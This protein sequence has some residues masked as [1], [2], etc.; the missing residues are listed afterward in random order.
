MGLGTAFLL[1]AGM[2]IAVAKGL[3]RDA[4]LVVFAASLGRFAGAWLSNGRNQ[5][6][7]GSSAIIA[8][9]NQIELS[10]R[11][12]ELALD[13]AQK[14]AVTKL[15]REESGLDFLGAIH[16]IDAFIAS[17]PMEPHRAKG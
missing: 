6:R 14:T 17:R 4:Q 10:D 3:F 13:P 1:A 8:P 11:V 7:Y 15:C 9:E 16:A 12:R 2:N 5:S